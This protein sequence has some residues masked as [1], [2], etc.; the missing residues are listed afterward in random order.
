M[1][2]AAAFSAAV[3]L[4]FGFLPDRRKVF[5]IQ[6][7]FALCRNNSHQVVEVMHNAVGEPAISNRGLS[8]ILVAEATFPW[9]LANAEKVY[10]R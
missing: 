2:N 3:R 1:V 9:P 5:Q 6:Y 7:K 8:D 4:T 10:G